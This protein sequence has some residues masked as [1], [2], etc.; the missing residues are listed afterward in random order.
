MRRTWQR[1]HSQELLWGTNRERW[2]NLFPH[3]DS[4]FIWVL[5]SHW[6]YRRVFNEAF[7]SPEYGHLR[8]MRHKSPRVTEMW[9]RGVSR[10]AG[11]ALDGP[12]DPHLNPLPEGEEAGEDSC[13]TARPV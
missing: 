5:K 3:P 1:V 8:V 7:A 13:G 2:F 10:I 9:M 11:A 12:E 4:L 6:R